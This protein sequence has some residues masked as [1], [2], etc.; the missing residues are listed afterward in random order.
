MFDTRG[1]IEVLIIR[2]FKVLRGGTKSISEIQATC[3][4]LSGKN[5]RHFFQTP[6]MT[7]SRTYT[8]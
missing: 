2:Y 1:I 4:K 3:V 8:L 5:E 6:M 7:V